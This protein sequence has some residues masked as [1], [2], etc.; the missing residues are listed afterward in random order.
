[1]FKKGDF[2]MMIKVIYED[3]KHDMLKDFMLGKYIE[4]GRIRKFK[5]SD[6]WVTV[7]VDSIRGKGGTYKGTERRGPVP[8]HDRKLNEY[9][10]NL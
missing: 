9:H 7:G 8:L 4:S 10:S 3:D 6:G 5:R 2:I 1:L